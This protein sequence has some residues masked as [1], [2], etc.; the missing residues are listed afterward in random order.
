V[1]SPARTLLDNA[2]EATEDELE[3]AV[4]DALE[5][6]LV[7]LLQIGDVL[8][9]AGHGR[10]GAGVLA[11]AYRARTGASP[12]LTR[13][14]GE[15]RLRDLI[16]AAQPPAQEMNVDLHGYVPDLLWRGQLLIVEV[17]GWAFDRG[18]G[19][20]ENDRGATPA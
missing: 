3:Q 20:F 14:W 8:A 18:R 15:R 10:Q 16:R 17:D 2:A 4:D 13:S 11:K 1:T 7:R 12:A 6:K 9:R 5:R 19:K